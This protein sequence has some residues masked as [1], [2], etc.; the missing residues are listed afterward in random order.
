MQI[1]TSVL[2]YHEAH[3]AGSMRATQRSIV[4]QQ[5]RTMGCAGMQA[6]GTEGPRLYLLQGMAENLI[7]TKKAIPFAYEKDKRQ[8][9]NHSEPG[10]PLPQCW[11]DGAGVLCGVLGPRPQEGPSPTA[12]TLHF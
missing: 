9:Q 2:F 3:P 6:A 1:P 5:H 4:G 10:A 8:L 7:R 12:I 11:A